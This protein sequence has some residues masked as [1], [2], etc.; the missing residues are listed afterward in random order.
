MTEDHPPPP[1][2]VAPYVRALGPDLAVRFFLAF[3]GADLAIGANPQRRSRLVRTVG[4]E[5]A[6]RLADTP[7]LPKR[8]P[9]AK[10]WCARTMAFRG[11]PTAE[12]ARR[13]HAS[14]VAVRRWLSDGGV[15]P[16]RDDRQ[17]SLF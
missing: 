2:H 10:P 14:D 7:G 8:V 13:L 12:I 4:F 16:R 11:L 6:R 1:A 5:P 3:G 9:L 15:D 17:R